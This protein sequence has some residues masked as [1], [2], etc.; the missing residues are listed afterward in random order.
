M[1][2]FL[3]RQIIAAGAIAVVVV[4]GRII[5]ALTD[6][7]TYASDVGAENR[8]WFVVGVLLFALTLAVNGCLSVIARFR[9]H[10]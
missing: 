3:K 7:T 9:R 4:V 5:T 8:G 10:P 1:K 6:G 2:P